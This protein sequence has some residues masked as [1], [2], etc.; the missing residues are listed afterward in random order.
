MTGTNESRTFSGLPREHT[1]YLF[2][3]VTG[4]SKRVKA[5]E[6]AEEFLS[7]G[8]T[9]DT[10]EEEKGIIFTTASSKTETTGKTWTA[11][12]VGTKCSS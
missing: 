6:I 11:D 2:G 8:W 3:D 1:D 4:L 10:L 12:Q 5:D 9:K 7:K